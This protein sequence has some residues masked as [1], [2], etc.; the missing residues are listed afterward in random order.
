MDCLDPDL[1]AA[2]PGLSW[3]RSS[4]GPCFPSSVLVPALTA[5][6]NLIHYLWEAQPLSKPHFHIYWMKPFLICP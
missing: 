5:S 3:P 6:S 2:W 1:A 4:R